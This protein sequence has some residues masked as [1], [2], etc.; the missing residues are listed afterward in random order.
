MKLDLAD[1]PIGLKP[2]E[3][4]MNLNT[5]N[6][7]RFPDTTSETLNSFALSGR[8]VDSQVLSGKSLDSVLR[9]LN[10]RGSGSAFWYDTAML[11]HFSVAVASRLNS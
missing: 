6:F 2:K 1:G 7:H 8:Y 11:R 10:S 3:D 9:E 5:T 4:L